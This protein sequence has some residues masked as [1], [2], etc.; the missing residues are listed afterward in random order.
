MTTP[1]ADTDVLEQ[2]IERLER[3]REPSRALDGLIFKATQEKLGDVWSEE[4]G[5]VWH[6]QDPE[7]RVA[8]DPPPYF[9][10]SVDAALTLVPEGDGWSVQGN[11]NVSHAM[12]GSYSGYGSSP[13][14]ALSAAA[15]RARLHANSNA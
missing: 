15:L 3:A 7:D 8:Y 6:R 5:D 2:L 12:V 11:T 9:T 10:G 13:A 14:R 4:I 1:T